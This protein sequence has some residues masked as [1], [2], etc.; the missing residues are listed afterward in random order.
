MHFLKQPCGVGTDIEL[1][2]LLQ[3]ARWVAN[4]FDNN[5]NFKKPRRVW[6]CQVSAETKP[7]DYY[8]IYTSMLLAFPPLS[9][10]YTHKATN[11]RPF[12]PLSLCI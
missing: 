12:L 7:E 11:L 1:V 6:F 9:S 4:S 3:T 5:N 10:L 8:R 2:W